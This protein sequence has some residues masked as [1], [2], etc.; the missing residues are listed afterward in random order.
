MSHGRMPRSAALA[1]ATLA[2]VAGS[3]RAE[4][5]LPPLDTLPLAP[6]EGANDPLASGLAV[7]V[8][9]YRVVGSSVFSPADF[10]RVTAAYRGRV[11]S[12]TELIAARDAITRLYQLAGYITSSAVIPDQAL[13]AG[14]IVV[15]EAVEAG[16]DDVRVSGHHSFRASYFRSRL[17]AA[18][19]APLD[20]HRIEEVLQRLQQDPVIERIN[21]RLVPGEER[22]ESVLELEVVGRTRFSAMVRGSNGYSPALGGEGA[23]IAGGVANLLG[24]GDTLVAEVNVAQGLQDYRG[25][26]DVAIGRWDTRVGGFYRWGKS[27]I[28]TEPFASA[29]LEGRFE[30]YG[31][32]AEHPLLRTR[33]QT[34]LIGLVAERRESDN[35][36]F[37]DRFDPS[38]PANPVAAILRFPVTWTWRLPRDGIAVY[39]MLNVG[40]DV[41][42]ATKKFRDGY[43]LDSNVPPAPLGNCPDGE[44]VSWLG[45]VQWAH[46]LWDGYWESRIVARLS[47]Q[48]ASDPLLAF[49]KFAL[50][51]IDTVRGY[52]QN[53]FVRDNG[54]ASSFE[55]WVPVWRSR[56]GRVAVEMAPFVDVGRAWDVAD[57]PAPQPGQ[58]VASMGLGVRVMPWEWFFAEFFWGGRLV[59]VPRPANALQRDGI[60]FNLQLKAF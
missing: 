48:L 43:C 51:G 16:L 50:G 39:S 25:A 11:I 37:G 44:F 1:L 27:Q 13:G 10:D 2:L 49:E 17:L 40:L 38:G 9:G 55:L 21:A 30:S 28:V 46:R 14:G 6:V 35:F 3:V 8:E 41:L 22:G 32:N 7:H 54:L 23:E 52:A 18:G 15:I 33:S 5:A 19:R 24:F 20:A 26:Y 47:V 36:I 59:E 58:T 45:Q 4:E 56:R 34:L 29:N 42:G 31:L 53:R 60:Y 12:Q 57:Q